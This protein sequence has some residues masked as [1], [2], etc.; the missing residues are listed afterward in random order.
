MTRIPTDVS[1]RVRLPRDLAWM[2][3]L[4]CVWGTYL[5]VSEYGWAVDSTAYWSAWQGALYEQP[6]G[7]EGAFLYSP[8]FAQIL[9][10]FV[11][12]PAVV[13][14]VAFA[15]VAFGVVWWLS[16]PLE[17]AWRIPLLLGCVFEFATGNINW[18]FAVVVAYGL[19]YPALW[20]IPAL[21]KI[22]PCLG[23]V[24]FLARGEWRKLAAC[25]AWIGAVVGV[26]LVASPELWREW[27]EF[28]RENLS[29]SNA[30]LGGSLLPPLVVRAPATLVMVAVGARFDK[31]WVIPVGMILIAP[32][33]GMGSLAILAGL[34]RLIH[35]SAV[36]MH[37]VPEEVRN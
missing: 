33:F 8:A 9:W 1:V 13:F 24:W 30:V 32:V 17:L 5:F 7:H 37:D 26:S 19:R 3:S 20:A 4:V 2:L 23:P 12:V 34:P 11:Q 21:T 16:R 28:L 6:P 15:L 27:L 22:T 36:D 31:Y 35:N 10:P 29:G 14:T 18:L 25:V